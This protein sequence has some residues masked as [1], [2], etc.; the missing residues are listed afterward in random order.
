M[1][2]LG[3]RTMKRLIR[4]PLYEDAKYAYMCG[5]C[6]QPAFYMSYLPKDKEAIPIEKIISTD[7]TPIS[8]SKM[9]VECPGCKTTIR[10]LDIGAF[11]PAV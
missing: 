6:R 5:S 3:E 11:I 2:E 9:N 10:D 1:S 8:I 7:Y 4:G